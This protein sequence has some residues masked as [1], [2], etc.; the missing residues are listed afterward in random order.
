MLFFF[1][2]SGNSEWREAALGMRASV[3]ALPMETALCLI[4]Q[5]GVRLHLPPLSFYGLK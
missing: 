4:S 3:C 1:Y 2:I 5:K